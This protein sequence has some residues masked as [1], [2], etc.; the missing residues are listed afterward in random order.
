MKEEIKVTLDI[1]EGI[2]IINFQNKD[3]V[4]VLHEETG[5]LYSLDL[6]GFLIYE[7]YYDYTDEYDIH[8]LDLSLLSNEELVVLQKIIYDFNNCINTRQLAEEAENT[9]YSNN[10]K[11]PSLTVLKYKALY[12]A[13]AAKVAIAKEVHGEDKVRFN[14][15]ESENSFSIYILYSEVTISN[16]AKESRTIKN[17]VVALDFGYR[18]GVYILTNIIRGARLT[19]ENTEAIV[20]YAHSHLPSVSGRSNFNGFCLGATEVAA[21]NQDLC[22]VDKYSD[23]KYKLFL[24]MIGNYLEHESL[25]GGPYIRMSSI[26]ATG[27]RFRASDSILAYTDGAPTTLNGESFPLNPDFNITFNKREDMFSIVKDNRFKESLIRLFKQIESSD[28]Y[29]MCHVVDGY[30][31]KTISSNVDSVSV[32]STPE[33][34]K[35]SELF[36]IPITS[37]K[38]TSSNHDYSK[39]LAPSLINRV[40]GT[41]EEKINKHYIEK[42][43]TYRVEEKI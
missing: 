38:D 20:G 24:H 31:Y 28:E 18:S 10:A 6:E 27:P 22:L 36:N 15:T 34:D 13:C 25:T 39:E 41:L 16:T 33:T 32:S 17:M 1:P 21:I 19:Y 42:Y 2:R 40:A 5:S 23:V 37:Y 9:F 35:V 26:K 29:Y 8:N 30:E 4:G 7:D 14:I 43:A 3:L 11:F 12:E